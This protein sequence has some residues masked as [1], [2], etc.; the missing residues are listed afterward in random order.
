[1]PTLLALLLASCASF[2][3]SRLPL[4]S[5]GLLILT[6]VAWLVV[7]IYAKKVLRSLRP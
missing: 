7:F 4:P 1:M 6:T 2:L 5:W 3:I